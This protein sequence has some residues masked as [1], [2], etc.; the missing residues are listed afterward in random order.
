MEPDY[1]LTSREVVV[2]DDRA[3]LEW[4]WLR[5]LGAHVPLLV[6]ISLPLTDRQSGLLFPPFAYTQVGGFGTVVPTFITL[7]RSADATVGAGIFTGAGGHTNAALGTRSVMGPRFSLEFRYAPVEG[8]RGDLDLDLVK[9]LRAKESPGSPPLADVPGEVGSSSGRGFDGVRGTVRFGHRTLAGNW[10]AAV[11]GTVATDNM[12]IPDTQPLQLDRYL[13]ALRTDAGVVRATDA[14]SLGLD[15]TLLQDVRIANAA[16]PDRRLFGAER[17]ATFQRLPSGFFQIAPVPLGPLAFSTEAS[18]TRFGPFGRLDPQETFTGFAPTDLAPQPG[19]FTDAPPADVHDPKGLARA[20]TVRFDVAPRLS[21]GNEWSPVAVAADVGARADAWLFDD[22]TQR[23]QQRAYATGGLRAWTT[24]SRS[25]GNLLHAITP[26]VEVRGNTPSVRSGSSQL[27]GD[28]TDAGGDLFSADPAAAQQGVARAVPLRAATCDPSSLAGC[29]LGVPAARRPYDEIDGAAPE[30]GEALARA[31][32]A[33]AFWS[34]G[35]AGHAPNRVAR[36]V[37]SQDAVLWDGAGHARLGEAGGLL[38][39]GIGPVSVN[40]RLQLDWRLR[41]VTLVDFSVG[42]RSARGD[43]LHA[44][45]LLLRG[46]ASEQLRA[47]IDELFAGARIAADAGD[48]IGGAGFGG[49]VAVPAGRQGL[50]LAYDAAYHLGALPPDIADWAHRLAVTYE[51]PCR[52]ASLQLAAV[53]PFRGGKLLRGPSLS[54]VFD[55]KSLGS[56]GTP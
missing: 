41:A 43:E 23:N 29:T 3:R 30:E 40:G 48:L 4:P 44:S 11:Q 10:L 31:S 25:F 5:L 47:G 49:S 33:Q 17:R 15:A 20:R 18:V 35:A 34:R 36:F 45:T 39:L 52:C 37:L 16:L 46:V 9:D 7:G 55:L 28:P 22:D 26:Q 50:R 6:P 56:F 2:H 38:Q 1:E 24:L 19:T 21:F 51:T 27:I 32:V 54:V 8:T 12:I 42:A 53:L 14:L 13:D